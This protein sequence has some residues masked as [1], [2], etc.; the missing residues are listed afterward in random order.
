MM[1]SQI[2]QVLMDFH[3]YLSFFLADSLGR[4]VDSRT[5][6]QIFTVVVPAVAAALDQ[7]VSLCRVHFL[8]SVR[9][10]RESYSVK[11][12]ALLHEGFFLHSL[13]FL[14]LN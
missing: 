13:V 10:Q 4:V 5:E 14:Y 1:H 11:Q 9:R 2:V 6:G 3:P 8:G 12:L 7:L